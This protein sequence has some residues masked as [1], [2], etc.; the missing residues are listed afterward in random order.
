MVGLTAHCNG[1]V[2]KIMVNVI[3]TPRQFVYEKSVALNATKG[4]QP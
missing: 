2:F 3:V 1:A 4:K